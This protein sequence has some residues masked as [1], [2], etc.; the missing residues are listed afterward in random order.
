MKVYLRI[1]FLMLGDF[2]AFFGAF[3]LIAWGYQLCGGKYELVTYFRMW[4]F[5]V[6]FILINE[7][8]KL[9]HGTVLYPGAAFG[10]AEEFK[11][12]FYAVSSVLFGILLFLFIGK[13]TE[14]YSRFIFVISWPVMFLGVIITRWILR[15]IFK[16]YRFGFIPAIILGAGK[17]GINISR[18]L[19]KNK[20]LGIDPVAFLDDNSVLHNTS[21]NDVPVLGSIDQL[22]SIADHLNIDYIIVCF[23]MDVISKVLKEYCNSFKHVMIIPSGTM[24]STLWVHAYDVGGILGLELRCNLL[25]KWPLFLKQATDYGLSIIIFTLAFPLMLFCAMMIKLTSQG[26]VI[27]KAKRLGLY[28]KPFEVYKFRT[29][30]MGADKQLE[31]YL[32][33]NPVAKKE[34]QENFKLKKDPRVTWFGTILRR[35]SLDELPQLLNVLKGNM[36]LIGP[37]PIVESE[38]KQYADNYGMIAS[39]K[40]G[41]TG[42]W[43]VSGRSGT[44]YDE[45]VKL[46]C[47]Y[48]M[49]WNIW[50]D[51]F[52]IFKTVK[53]VFFCNGAY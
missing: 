7:I 41:I 28:G 43:Q 49:N 33:N 35:T 44:D 14:S 34:W 17:N 52:I 22:K 10:P 13:E 19:Q 48:L 8:A 45:R 27:Y 26:P 3:M 39:I 47:Y 18:I 16:Y 21:I 20:Y 25:L 29:M 30:R 40:P 23:P 36:S 50:L 12:L 5:G 31:A 38:L 24:F 32:E 46:D 15:N 1:V 2:L 11:R 37:R 53:E 42:L 6:L 4:P 9:Y 51:F